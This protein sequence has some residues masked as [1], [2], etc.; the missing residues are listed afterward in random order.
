MP[1]HL[2][3]ATIPPQGKLEEALANQVDAINARITREVWLRGSCMTDNLHT[4]TQWRLTTIAAASSGCVHQLVDLKHD[5]E[6]KFA[7]QVAENKRLQHHVMRVQLSVGRALL[8]HTRV[9][10]CFQISLQKTEATKL[11]QQIAALQERLVAVE[12]ELG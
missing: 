12:N 10:L 6:H 5:T 2:T 8:T 9:L 1:P 4:H 3:Y 7:L 11:Q